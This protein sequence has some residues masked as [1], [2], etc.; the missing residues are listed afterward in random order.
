MTFIVVGTKVL[1][2]NNMHFNIPYKMNIIYIYRWHCAECFG[3]NRESL[4]WFTTVDNLAG[5]KTLKKED[6]VGLG[7]F[8]F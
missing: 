6:Q 2:N 3:K 5:L 8:V 4:E 1:L 7:L